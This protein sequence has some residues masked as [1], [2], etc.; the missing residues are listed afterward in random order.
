[1]NNKTCPYCWGTILR[2]GTAFRIRAASRHDGPKIRRAFSNLDPDTRYIRF[3]NFK[4][5][6][7]KEELALITHADFERAVV[8]LATIGVGKDE[9][10]IGEASYFVID[11]SA[12][13]RGAELSFIVEE[14]FQ[15][16]GVAGLLMKHLTEIAYS[17]GLGLLVADVLSCNMRM[18][19]VFRHCG[20]PISIRIEGNM[21]HVS[22][23]L[24]RRGEAAHSKSALATAQ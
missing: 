24:Q 12:I 16:R 18:L 19:N 17:K 9:L 11:P 4:K 5:D 2:D 20:L 10:V 7:G 6:L 13:E 1:M 23:S 21:L 8:L 3:F 15:G 14:G 22:L